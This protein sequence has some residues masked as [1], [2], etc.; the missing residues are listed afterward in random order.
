MKSMV[1]S[2]VILAAVGIVGSALACEP[3]CQ[4]TPGYWKNHTE[5]WV[6]L[7]PSDT[8]SSLFSSA[9]E[10]F[11]SMTLLDALQGGGGP[12]V[13][14]AT[15][16]LL[17]AAVASALNIQNCGCDEIELLQD[18]VNSAIEGGDRCEMIA[19]AKW[20]DDWNNGAW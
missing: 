6:G 4:L 7:S 3:E 12:G 1:K 20:L 11:A 14:G 13:E 10:P 18:D 15:K 16:I 2:L 8:V 5:A 9:P 19:L 17:R